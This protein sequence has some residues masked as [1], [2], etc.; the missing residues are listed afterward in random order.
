MLNFEK[1]VDQLIVIGDAPGNTN[2]EIKKRRLHK[3][4]IYWKKDSRFADILEGDKLIGEMKARNIAVHSFYIGS[5]PANY[6]QEL[7]K[8]TAG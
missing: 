2:E 4:E 6:F 7:S 8:A 1:E 3:G 5:G